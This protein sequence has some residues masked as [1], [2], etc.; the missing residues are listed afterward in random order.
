MDRWE[1]VKAN[2]KRL[3]QDPNV[4]ADL[5]RAMDHI[6]LADYWKRRSEEEHSLLNS[7]RHHLEQQESELRQETMR[8]Q[9]LERAFEDKRRIWEKER[10]ALEEKLKVKETEIQLLRERSEWESRFQDAVKNMSGGGRRRGLQIPGESDE[11]FVGDEVR[12]L[13][14]EMKSLRDSTEQI[15]SATAWLGREKERLLEAVNGRSA[16]GANGVDTGILKEMMIC[17]AQQLG[18]FQADLF[19]KLESGVA[20]LAPSPAPVAAATTKDDAVVVVGIPSSDGDAVKKMWQERLQKYLLVQEDVARGFCHKA[21]NLLGII[22]GTAQIVLSDE[23][24]AADMKENLTTIDQNVTLMLDSIEEFLALTRYPQLGMEPTNLNQ[25]LQES[26]AGSSFQ[27]NLDQTLPT[28]HVDKKLVK[29]AF[30]CI[31]DNAREAGAEGGQIVISS[32]FD[33]AEKSVTLSFKDHGK[34]IGENHFRKVF[35][36]YFTTKKDQRGLGLSKALHVAML[37]GGKMNVESV[38]G[39]GTT[40]HFILP[41]V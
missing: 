9:M 19:K 18:S 41:T 14:K 10:E 24:L 22:S 6:S 40:V 28:L 30:G 32:K 8:S 27:F 17:M 34:G 25:L 23:K 16:A 2:I 35:Q 3:E 11:D 20:A 13:M 38:K 31:L 33:P 37:H 7:I 21:R 36:P 39:A 5:L 4:N 1:E 12:R 26:A 29:E 15:E